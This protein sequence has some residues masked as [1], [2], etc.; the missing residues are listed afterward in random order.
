MA[1]RDEWQRFVANA[2]EAQREYRTLE[3]WHGQLDRVYR[4]VSN[5]T[6]VE[7]TLEDDAPRD[8][9]KLVPFDAST[10]QI[11]EP[12]ERQDAE[13]ALQVD[14]GNVDGTI[15]SILDQIS[16]PGYF[17]AVQIIYRKYY[18]G[19]LSQPAVPSLRLF[20]SGMSFSGPTT[21]SFTA[22]DVDLSQKRA[23]S[24]YTSEAFP[25]LRE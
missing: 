14:F 16:G 5:Y 7:F 2:P 8:R 10:L 20:A 12:A 18:S 17:E 19:D 21:V 25:G 3:V 1:T 24:L 9:G 22:E 6:P 13:Q 23:G 4:F 15:H 11:V